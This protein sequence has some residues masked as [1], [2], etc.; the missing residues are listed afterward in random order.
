MIKEITRNVVIH[1]YMNMKYGNVCRHHHR[2][3]EW[4]PWSE[5]EPAW[6]QP[7]LSDGL[8]RCPSP[9]TKCSCE[10]WVSRWWR[11]GSRQ[12][13]II[14]RWWE[15]PHRD[16]Q[17]AS[18]RASHL[19]GEMGKNV[20]NQ[21][22]NIFTTSKVPNNLGNQKP[23]Q[24][25]CAKSYL[26]PALDFHHDHVD[27]CAKTRKLWQTVTRP[28][29]TLRWRNDAADMRFYHVTHSELGELIRTGLDSN[30]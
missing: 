16:W 11:W 20:Q 8:W 6:R 2:L 12:W 29:R 1:G 23:K 4:S 30:I 5:S 9:C 21:E 24:S 13:R 3:V 17:G 10:L 15:W 25:L 28:R 22:I 7:P 18:H 19:E 26:L 14:L 27:N